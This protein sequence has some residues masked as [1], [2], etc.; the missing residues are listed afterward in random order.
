MQK[1][2]FIAALLVMIL[3]CGIMLVDR[4]ILNHSYSKISDV[5]NMKETELQLQQQRQQQQ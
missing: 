3:F 1:I 2:Y 4:H 5:I